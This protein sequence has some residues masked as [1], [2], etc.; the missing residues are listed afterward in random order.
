MRTTVSRY[1][2]VF[3]HCLLLAAA[4]GLA[5]T[6]Q[7]EP[8]DQKS[9]EIAGK[10]AA[11]GIQDRHKH[12]LDMLKKVSTV[13]ADLEEKRRLA[14]PWRKKWEE[15]Q[16][17]IKTI[18]ER[19]N[20]LANDFENKRELLRYV[21]QAEQNFSHL[22]P[23]LNQYK[24]WAAL[25]EA[26]TNRM[27]LIQQDLNREL[28]P[29]YANHAQTN[30]LHESI[31]SLSSFTVNLKR[32]NNEYR[33]YLKELQDTEKL[34]VRIL[35]Q[36]N[37]DLAQANHLKT[38][39]QKTMNEVEEKLPEL[40]KNYYL[41]KPLT[42]LDASAWTNLPRQM[43]IMISGLQMRRSLELPSDANGW[44]KTILRAVISCVF[45]AIAL[46]VLRRQSWL[47]TDTNPTI[48][49]LF[50]VSLPLIC[51][52]LAL[53][54]ASFYQGSSGYRLFRAVGNIIMIL[55][56]INLAWDLRLLSSPTTK[57]QTSPVL[58]LFPLTCIA[59]TLLYL[60]LL[61]IVL[62]ILWLSCLIAILIWRRFWPELSI[63]ELRLEQNIRSFDG[64]V[65][66][67]C[68]LLT[69]C[70]LPIFSMIVYLCCVS[71]SIALQLCLGG[72][73]RFNYLNENQPQE[74]VKAILSN[75]IVSLTAPIIILG[76]VSSVLLW[77]ATLPGGMA[78]M[79]E[80]LFKNVSIGSAEF[81]FIHIL[82]IISAFFLTKAISVSGS[83]YLSK[84]IVSQKSTVDATLVTPAQTAFTYAIWI[85]FAL[86]VMHILDIDLK[87]AAMV[88]TGLSVGIGM[89]LQSIVNNFFSGLLLIFGRMLQVGDVI[90]VGG[91]SGRVTKISVRDTLIRTYDN[92]YIYVPNSEFIS[93]HLVNWSR[94]DSTVRSNVT[95]GVAYGS[96]TDKVIKILQNIVSKQE[97]VLR[98]PEPSVVFKEFGDSALLFSV[99][100]WVN[101]FDDKISTS[102]AVRLQINREFAKNNIEIAFPQIDVHMK[103][104]TKKKSTR[105]SRLGASARRAL[106]QGRKKQADK[107]SD[108][109]DDDTI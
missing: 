12:V 67:I 50:R 88:A 99:F 49:H 59:Y 27:N 79:D 38:E 34:L 103:E 80:Y 21:A 60:P 82:I 85:I 31:L 43:D 41:Q 109:R 33:L 90:E 66:W 89:G 96:D 30:K 25:M 6:A 46:I 74:G 100:F 2:F 28:G 101:K 95:V 54:I 92:A 13:F 51:F 83:R 47:P 91:I 94:N 87:N 35:D 71:I 97:K 29:L 45:F 52:G 55:G 19:A 7:A 22:L 1:F 86:F 81:N 73:D 53:L 102:T 62:L 20:K 69:V 68:L 42:W 16:D 11:P 72:I 17:R 64:L 58:R 75:I 108:Y 48:D 76:T 26:I 24:Q 14:A 23:S 9:P 78:L 63:G 32:D 15:S 106:A 84:I 44:R 57:R 65:L 77:L 107:N 93:G 105:R 3:I 5:S 98:Y 18:Q 8:S 36:Q 39:I 61:P 37:N 40:W 4:L 104:N 56:Q 10:E 70:G